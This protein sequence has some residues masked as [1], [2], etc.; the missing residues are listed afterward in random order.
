MLNFLYVINGRVSDGGVWSQSKLRESI[1]AGTAS[2]PQATA[3]PG[4]EKILPYCIV[5]DDAFPLKTYLMKPFSY[6]SQ[7]RKDF[8]LIDYLAQGE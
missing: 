6:K 1:E 7:G 8:F 2:L 4:S 3:L 5:G